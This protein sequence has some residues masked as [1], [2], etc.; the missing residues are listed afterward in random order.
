VHA[1]G[2]VSLTDEA[3]VERFYADL[4]PWASVHLAGGFAMSPIAETR[5]ADYEKMHALNAI[6]AFLC[7]REAVRAMRRGGGGGRIVNVISRAALAPGA[8][9]L[10]YTASKAEVAALT[11][12]L[13]AEV[14]G[15]RIL[16]NAI[17]PSIID[18]PANRASM[19]GVDHATWPKAEE[20]AQVIGFL[21]GTSNTLISGAL[22]P[23]YG[24][25]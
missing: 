4:H 22:V 3:A 6:T 24:R 5:L 14:L 13:A 7:A 21:A 18:T 11:E 2:G 15:D 19:P 25:A 12:A 9:S 10:A 20:I 23:V 1:T 16:V 8:G 17:A